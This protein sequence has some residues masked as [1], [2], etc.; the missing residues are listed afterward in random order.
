VL[1]GGGDAGA[2][3]DAIDSFAYP[4]E[5]LGPVSRDRGLVELAQAVRWLTSVPAGLFG[6]ADRGRIRPGSWAD[7][8]LFD[9]ATVAPGPL[10]LRTDLPAGGRR[11][12]SSARGIHSVWVNGRELVSGGEITGA[13]SGQL[14][15]AGVS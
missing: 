13:R 12:W 1:I 14:I 15:R 7:L 11:L 4:T 10:E 9:P 8:V 5:L 3:L 2:H 6:M